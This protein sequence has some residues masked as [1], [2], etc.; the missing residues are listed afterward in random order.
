MGVSRGVNHGD[1]HTIPTMAIAHGRR[2]ARSAGLGTPCARGSDL[3]ETR[4]SSHFGPWRA[5]CSRSRRGPPDLAG[6]SNRVCGQRGVV[7]SVA[8]QSAVS[9][10]RRRPTPVRPPSRAKDLSVLPSRARVPLADKK[11][12]KRRYLTDETSHRR[13][14]E[15][16]QA[17]LMQSMPLLRLLPRFVL[18]PSIV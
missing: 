12:L 2:E 11:P 9:Q 4:F 1:I 16:R 14:H 8:H 5:R 17:H 3:G 18:D 7:K 10:R 13:Q 15:V 6:T